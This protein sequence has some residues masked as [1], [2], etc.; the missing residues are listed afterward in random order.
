MQD[1][2]PA[3]GLT[4]D[5]ATKMSLP[6][7][8]GTTLSGHPMLAAAVNTIVPWLVILV[9]YLVIGMGFK[10]L[11]DCLFYYL[12]RCA[13][14]ETPM[15]QWSEVLKGLHAWKGLV[16]YN[17][18]NF[19]ILTL[20]LM[21][22]MILAVL[23]VAML[24]NAVAGIGIFLAI[25]SFTYLAVSTYYG[26][27]VVIDRAGK[28]F[29]G[30]VN[31]WRAFWDTRRRLFPYWLVLLVILIICAVSG[32]IANSLVLGALSFLGSIIPNAVLVVPIIGLLV[33]PLIQI[34]TLLA[35]AVNYRAIFADEAPDW[36]T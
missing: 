14:M 16:K 7:V 3:G 30:K 8:G 11:C 31:A 27:L 34:I 26:P 29:G 15:G 22:P 12:A 17:V 2:S 10:I 21:V 33:G 5:D 25:I 6:Q 1:S 9:L 32:G 20:T 24:G 23:L 4:H 36:G 35:M 18:W 28:T 19:I 13:S